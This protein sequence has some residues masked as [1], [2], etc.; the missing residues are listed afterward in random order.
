MDGEIEGVGSEL[1]AVKVTIR[2]VNKKISLKM[3][4]FSDGDVAIVEKIRRICQVDLGQTDLRE[5]LR[6]LRMGSA[7]GMK[8]ELCS[9]LDHDQR[10]WSVHSFDLG[11]QGSGR[12]LTG[13]E[14]EQD[15]KRPQDVGQKLQKCWDRRQ[16]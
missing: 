11:R 12:K 16:V 4:S 7:E 8:I 2:W 5:H 15:L 6:K 9:P 1:Q 10:L 13:L 14:V 3:F